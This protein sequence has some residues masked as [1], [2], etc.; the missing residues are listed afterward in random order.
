MR[1]TFTHEEGIATVPDVDAERAAFFMPGN[2]VH[3][4]GGAKAN[5][6]SQAAIELAMIN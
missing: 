1:T 3:C 6:N 2:E 4:L 5:T